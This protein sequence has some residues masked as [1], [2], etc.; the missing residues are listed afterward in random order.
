MN[1]KATLEDDWLYMVDSSNRSMMEFTNESW[2]PILA[3]SIFVGRVFRM[4]PFQILDSPSCTQ[5]L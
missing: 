1:G 3:R 4:V 5:G 2:W